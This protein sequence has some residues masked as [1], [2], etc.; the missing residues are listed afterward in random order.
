MIKYIDALTQNW[1]TV[2]VMVVGSSTTYESMIW[3][4]GSSIPSK[5]DMDA[6]IADEIK[7]RMWLKIQDERNKRT[8]SGVKVTYN[9]IDYWFHSDSSSRIQQLGL[10]IMGAGLPPG[11]MWKTMGGSFVEMTQT[12]AGQI[13]Q[14]I[15]GKDQDMYTVAEQHKA[16]MLASSDPE[17]Y[18][19]LTGSPTWPLVYGE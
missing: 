15:A 18:N 4:S 7:I 17:N 10:V 1:P 11:I 2:R 5:A 12:L 6:W 14:S 3:Q 19:Y 16:Q 13:F 8:Q 9:A